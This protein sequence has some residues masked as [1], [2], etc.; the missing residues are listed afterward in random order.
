MLLNFS[1]LPEKLDAAGGVYDGV[2]GLL[3]GFAAGLGT[4]PFGLVGV[5]A[6]GGGAA[7]GC[8]NA[9]TPLP[10]SSIS[11]ISVSIGVL[12]TNLTKKSCSMTWGE[13]AR[14]AGK[15]RSKRPKRL[16]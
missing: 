12:P 1:F 10:L 14:M 6:A 15:R 13:T 16:G 11:R 3:A 8:W 9:G 7:K 4:A 5:V 2:T